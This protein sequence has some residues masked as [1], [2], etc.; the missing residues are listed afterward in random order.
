VASYP[1]V[2]FCFTVRVIG[3]GA[4]LQSA[5][6]ADGSFQEVSGL[7]AERQLE[8]VVAGGSNGRVL[9]LP[10]GVKYPNLVLKRGY[11][12]SASFLSEWVAQ[13][14]TSDLSQPIFTQGLLVA[15]CDADQYPL[16]TWYAAGAWPVKWVTGPLDSMKNEV[17][18]E[19]LEFTYSSITRVPVGDAG[20]MAMVGAVYALVG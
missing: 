1:A 8:S 12:S 3:S 15:L 5:S 11:I 16:V 7:E 9:Q 4:V 6:G 19:Q 2:G 13:T 10:N 18:T 14:V 20:S 17:L